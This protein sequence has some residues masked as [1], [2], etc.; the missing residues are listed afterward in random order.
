MS[1]LLHEVSSL[2]SQLQ[3]R[4][5][6]LVTVREQLGVLEEERESW[7]EEVERVRGERDNVQVRPR[8]ESVIWCPL[9]SLLIKFTPGIVQYK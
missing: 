1:G 9:C 3:Q 4:E 6:E 5:E 2:S 8:G 7:K